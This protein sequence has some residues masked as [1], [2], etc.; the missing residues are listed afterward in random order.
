[1][2]IKILYEDANILAIDKPSGIAAHA[3]GRNKE[4]AVTDWVLKNYPKMKNVGEPMFI[5]NKGKKIEIKRPGVVHRLDRDT[6]G[7]ML[8]AKNEKAYEF[9]K[10][11]FQNREV[12][13]TY[14]AIISGWLKEE[15]GVINKP[16]G[17]SPSD[18][19]KYSA[20]RGARGEMREASTRYR[21]L[22][23]FALRA[24]KFTYIEVFPKTGRTH[25]IRVHMKAIDHPIVCDPLYNPKGFC[26]KGISRMA[27]HAK[28][29]EFK[30]LKGKII[31]VESS[32]PPQ[33]KKLL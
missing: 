9:L 24:N 14:N 22:K 25:Q 3:D 6:S 18:F 15:R 21:V 30:D 13:K 23:R 4:K 26:L 28:A 16:I 27:L 8:L 17:R 10:K 12:K 20:S 31:R 5:E 7:V 19:R 29:I 32:L 11:Q 2:K 33:F 1:M